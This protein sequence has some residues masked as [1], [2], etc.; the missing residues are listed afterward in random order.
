VDRRRHHGI[1]RILY[2]PLGQLLKPYRRI[3]F[4]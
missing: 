3:A 1:L 4:P 2:I